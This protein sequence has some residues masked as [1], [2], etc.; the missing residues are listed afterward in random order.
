MSKK[1]E[2][3]LEKLKQAYIAARDA[4]EAA[5]NDVE[6]KR[7]DREAYRVLCDFDV[8]LF[9]KAQNKKLKAKLIACG[10]TRT[11]RYI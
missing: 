4:S 10:M 7:L 2:A 5:P 11:A 1:D 8:V 9:T 6:L 3:K